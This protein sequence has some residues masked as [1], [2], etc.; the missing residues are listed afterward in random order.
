MSDRTVYCSAVSA[1]FAEEVS[2]TYS[3]GASY[4]TT[5]VSDNHTKATK[6]RTLEGHGRDIDDHILVFAFI[7]CFVETLE[8]SGRNAGL[9]IASI[10][11][12]TSQHFHRSTRLHETY[13]VRLGD[14]EGAQVEGV[15]L[16]L[17]MSGLALEARA[18][19]P[20]G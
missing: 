6:W 19:E 18:W 17:P 1:S 2:Q 12:I 14:L 3:V 20:F 15:D 9:G 11:S 10:L 4:R 7:S 13:P 8:K 16:L 5:S